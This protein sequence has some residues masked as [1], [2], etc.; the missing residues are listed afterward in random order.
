MKATFMLGR[1][2]LGGFFLYNGINHFLKLDSMAQYASAKK[3]PMPEVAVAAS[4]ALLVAGGSSLITGVKP[5]LGA[6]A[7]VAFLVGVS[8]AMHDFWNM[9]DPQQ[10]QNDMINFSKNMALLGATVALGSVEEPWPASLAKDKRTLLK[11]VRDSSRR[12]RIAA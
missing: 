12:D 8:P 5:K 1:A 3:V 2:L 11:K 6:A 4:G 7:L 9:D 10:K